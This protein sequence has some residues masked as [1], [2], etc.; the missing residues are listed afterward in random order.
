MERRH[1]V[2]KGYIN[3]LSFSRTHGICTTSWDGSYRSYK[4]EE[5]RLKKKLP[6]GSAYLRE[7][8]LLIGDVDG[9]VYSWNVDEDTIMK[10]Y[11]HHK[12]L[13]T[14]V[15]FENHL[16]VSESVD[17]LVRIF[18][19]PLGS[20]LEEYQFDNQVTSLALKN[21]KLA[22]GFRDRN[23][24]LVF[25]NILRK[26]DPVYTNLNSSTILAVDVGN[27]DAENNLAIV[28]HSN[29]LAKIFNFETG[30]LI[31]QLAHP[32]SV[33]AVT[34]G[35]DCRIFLTASRFE[36]RLWDGGASLVSLKNSHTEIVNKLCI[37]PSS[38]YLISG[39]DDG[40]VVLWDL[41]HEDRQRLLILCLYCPLNQDVFK[42][43]WKF[44]VEEA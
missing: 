39:G 27:V 4:G 33:T 19:I 40:K 3:T 8:L 23:F 42:L 20:I 10:I 31:S 6:V 22:I 26:S 38:Q 41:L 16:G 37:T 29:G 30:K 18:S 2:Q 15:V 43:I 24:S 25:V 5:M 1:W 35:K 28:G 21:G 17:G 13:V 11:P 36:L 44:L 14:A 34:I 12:T 7:N 9:R 32:Y